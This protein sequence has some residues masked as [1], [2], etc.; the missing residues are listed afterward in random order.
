MSFSPAQLNKIVVITGVDIIR[1]QS[2]LDFYASH[3]TA[4][5]ETDVIAE[6]DRWD[7]DGSKFVK[8]HPTESNYGVETN[9]GDAKGDIRTNI[10]RLLFLTQLVSSGNYLARG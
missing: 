6:L 5:T 4:Q 8:L 1:L 9:S 10:S 7:T 3:I 2:V